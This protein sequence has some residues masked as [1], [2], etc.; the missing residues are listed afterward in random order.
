MAKLKNVEKP[1]E[2][3]EETIDTEVVTTKAISEVPVEKKEGSKAYSEKKQEPQIDMNQIYQMFAEFKSTIDT[4][5]DE[6]AE[7]KKKNEELARNAQIAASTP[8]NADRLIEI[9]GNKKSD[10]EVTIIHN[11]ELL[12]GLSTAIRLTG[13][14]IDF[15]TLG[16]ERILSWQ[17][18]EECVSKYR[19]WFDKQI[20]LLAPEHAEIAE[21]YNVPC[22]KRAGSNA[23]T[24]SELQNLY[25]KSERD[26]EDFVKGL[27]E[28][29]QSFV[30]SYW[31]GKCY[32]RDANYLNRSKIELLNRVTKKGAFDTL[33]TGMNFDSI[34][35]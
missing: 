7:E 34:R 26:L 15:H 20:I 12:G 17:Q 23:I 31:L 5:K 22:L 25:R 18:F 10:R 1:V 3:N 14:S 9:L 28:Q 6:L 27:T 19:K 29:D 13:M 11:R 30:C 2:N 21:R 35:S 8:S 32:E 24:K 4:L 33:L 16:E